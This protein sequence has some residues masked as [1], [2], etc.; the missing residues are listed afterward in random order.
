MPAYASQRLTLWAWHI[1]ACLACH[2]CHWG[3]GLT[4]ACGGIYV[5]GVLDVWMDCQ[6]RLAGMAPWGIQEW[7][8]LQTG[9]STV[10][11]CGTNRNT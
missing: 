7:S 5:Q 3:V 10:Q 6:A 4:P 11:T 9:T 1:A 2:Y 8:L